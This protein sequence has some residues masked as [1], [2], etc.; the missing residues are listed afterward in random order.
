MIYFILYVILASIASGF[1]YWDMAH[2]TVE[3]KED[4]VF[5]LPVSIAVGCFF[6]VAMPFYIA[7]LIVRKL[8]EKED[9]K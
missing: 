5:D 3:Y 1:V 2:R 6:P 7:F 9:K 4:H 8:R